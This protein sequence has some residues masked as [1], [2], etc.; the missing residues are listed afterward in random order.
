MMVVYSFVSALGDVGK[1]VAIVLLVFQISGTGGIY[2]VEIMDTIFN[3]LHPYLPMTYAITLIREAQLG[4]IWS[5]FIPALI[6]LLA[7]GLAAIIISIIIKEKADK[8]THY[9]EERLEESGLF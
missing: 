6:I 3:V 5:N 4:V 7:L 8:A 1:A 9:F 2:P